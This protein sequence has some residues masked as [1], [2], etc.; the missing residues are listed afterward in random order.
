MTTNH[1]NGRRIHLDGSPATAIAEWQ[2]D[3]RLAMARA[4]AP[5]D[6]VEITQG[7][8]VKAKAGDTEAADLLFT[9]VFWPRSEES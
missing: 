4:V 8:V 9:H 5:I 6:V 1:H 3:L 2:D 7:L